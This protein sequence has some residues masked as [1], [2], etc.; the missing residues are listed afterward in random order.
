MRRPAGTDARQPTAMDG[1]LFPAPAAPPRRRALHTVVAKPRALVAP[2]RALLAPLLAAVVLLLA[3]AGTAAAADSPAARWPAGGST[4][5]AA[6]W[7][8]G[9]RWGMTP[10]GGKVALGWASLGARTNAQASWANDADDPFSQPSSNSGCEIALS[11]Q[12][13][14]D[15]PKLCTV[16]VHEVGHLTGHPHVDDPDDVMYL[17]YVAPVPECASTPEPAETGAPRAAA[18]T[19]VKAKVKVKAKRATKRR[20]PARPRHR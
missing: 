12:A 3:G 7:L 16:V 10:C 15:W 1:R 5:R 14:W 4:L 11:L 20:A 19:K 13:E 9:E 17:S 2:P 6:L 8:G 18:K